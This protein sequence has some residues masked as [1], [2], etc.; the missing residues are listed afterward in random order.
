MKKPVLIIV[1][2]AASLSLISCSNQSKASSNTAGMKTAFTI[3]T[4]PEYSANAS[5]VYKMFQSASVVL[6]GKYEKD[7]KSFVE[8]DLIETESHIKVTK[9]LK[10]TL[11]DSEMKNGIDIVYYGGEVTLDTYLNNTTPV[12]EK[13]DSKGVV[14]KPKQYS[15]QER[16]SEKVIY[17]L[18]QQANKD[19]DKNSEIMVFLSRN[20]APNNYFV[21][22]DA[23]GYRKINNKGE[24]FNPDTNSYEKVDFYPT[25]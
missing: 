22:A 10:G 18:E 23:Y 5:S 25:D 19:K 11:T 13:V 4:Y 16:E 9:V 14:H 24:V 7:N 21:Q 6:V 12:P 15:K 1:S 2:I 20:P 8:R 17:K 3:T